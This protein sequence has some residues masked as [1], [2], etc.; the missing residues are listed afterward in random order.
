MCVH[1][2]D[3]EVVKFDVEKVTEVDDEE[4]ETSTEQ[5]V[6]VSGK[7]GNYSYVDLGLKNGA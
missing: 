2:S 7:V 5:G 3:G 4:S 6:T 1:T